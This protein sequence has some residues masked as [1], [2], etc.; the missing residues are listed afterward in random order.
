MST[1]RVTVV[2]LMFV[3]LL[4]APSSVM[5]GQQPA[6]AAPTYAV[7]P[8]GVTQ[9]LVLTDGTRMYGRIERVD[10]AKI[11]FRTIADAL[12]ET[13][14][15][16]VK[17]L[18]RVEGRN[19][20]GTFLQADPNPTRLFFGPTGRSLP[21]GS[22][23]LGVYEIFLPFVQ[24]GVTDRISIGGG[25]PLFFGGGSEHPFWFTP[26]VQILNAGRTQAAIGVMHFLNVDNGHFGVAYGAVTHGTSDTAITVAG[27]F[28]YDRSL[29]ATNTAGV[30]MIGGERRISRR[31]KL[32]TENYA[33][34]D[35]G[36]VSFGVRFMGERLSADLGMVMPI[37]TDETIA[38]PMV[39]VVWQFK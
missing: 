37:G 28:V 32:I 29:D 3:G 35:G 8:A 4:T 15:S 13:D 2:A 18:T 23:Y 19:V 10:G 6:P 24:V 30:V 11:Y 34:S 9:E 39:N 25:T 17:K 1:P 38:F 26:K 31:V 20:N 33:F 22:G 5:A 7:A 14:V 36:L 27:G 12:I 16:R 21:K